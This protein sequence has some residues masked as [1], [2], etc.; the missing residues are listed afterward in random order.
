MQWGHDFRPDY[1]E[2][3]NL[4]RDYPTVPIMCLTAT[5]NKS[6]V[7]DSIRI[8]GFRSDSFL[9]TQSFNRTNL[10]YSV[11]KK[12]GDNKSVIQDLAK[13]I[14]QNLNQ[15]G[16][17]YCLSK[18]NC[19]DV[20][21]DLQVELPEMRQKIDFYHADVPVD[22]RI[23]R[24]NAWS[25]GELMVLWYAINTNDNVIKIDDLLSTAQLL[26]LEW[27]LLSQMVFL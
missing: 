15:S 23:R 22:E 11:R 8:I 2:L 3:K 19:E 9:H 20:S 24:Q 18:Q 14:K 4:R 1:M 7:D 13:I 17:I 25:K 26:H 6:V 12:A 10:N 5:A 21:R 27:A 16:I